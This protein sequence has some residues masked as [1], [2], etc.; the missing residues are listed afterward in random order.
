MP[1]KF[2]QFSV[3]DDGC[4][5]PVGTDA[6]LLGAIANCDSV[7]S[8]LD[9][10]TGSGIIALMLAQRSQANI[11]AIEIDE[12][13]FLK[14]KKN[15]HNSPWPERLTAIHSSFQ[16]FSNKTTN[17][18]DL[19]VSNPPFFSNSLKPHLERKRI[20]KHDEQ[21]NFIELISGV[22]RLLKSHGKF[23]L[24]LPYSEKDKIVQIAKTQNLHLLN[25]VD[26]LPKATKK[27]NRAIL[28]FGFIEPK[29]IKSNSFTL[30]SP[31]NA[32]SGKYKQITKDF[33]PFY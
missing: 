9:I 22:A 11:D 3:D 5:M 28:E 1:F 27:P 4:S 32:Y 25:I 26:I 12:S 14:A 30:R 19:I 24:I 33:H 8:I 31:D 2:K 29:Q 17:T 15:F 23:T 18:Y 10:G 7:K 16:D 13:S 6:V 21:L 20:S